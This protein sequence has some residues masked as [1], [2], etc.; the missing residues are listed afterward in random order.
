[1]HGA[2]DWFVVEREQP[3]SSNPKV[4][5]VRKGPQSRQRRL[6]GHVF[7]P[8]RRVKPLSGKIAVDRMRA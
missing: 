5:K 2:G 1:M 6:A 4:R 8:L 7:A 3:K